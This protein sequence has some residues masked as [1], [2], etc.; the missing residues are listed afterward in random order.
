MES[1]FNLFLKETGQVLF[2]G[3]CLVPYMVRNRQVIDQNLKIFQHT[4]V[5]VEGIQLSNAGTP[6]IRRSTLAKGRTGVTVKIHI[7]LHE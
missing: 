4:E 3:Y 2:Y 7:I 5:L 1:D 6:S